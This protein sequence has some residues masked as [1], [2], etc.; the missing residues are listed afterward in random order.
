M[1]IK[2]ILVC[3]VGLLNLAAC[4]SYSGMG[5]QHHSKET[6]KYQTS[7]DKQTNR[8]NI[9]DKRRYNDYEQREQCQHYREIPRNMV[10]YC[11]TAED[12]V[13]LIS[14]HL[15]PLA[16]QS[17]TPLPIIRSYTILF[18]HNK[19]NIRQ[20]ENETLDRA[21]R[22]I[23]QYNPK[24]VTVTG[25]TD[26]SGEAA[27][28]QALSEDR[29]QAVSKALLNRGIQNQTLER[30][31]RGEY[32]QAIETKDGIRNQSNRRVVIDFRR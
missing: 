14:T 17:Q 12:D 6:N 15:M 28:N 16:Q 32:E 4:Q 23:S 19:S 13:D 2:S 10:D 24:Q 31:A 27:Y 20:N 29:E 22:E 5:G 9:I 18:D 8:V 26:S 30:E 11:K 7:Q 25:Y 3:T 1:K 21:M